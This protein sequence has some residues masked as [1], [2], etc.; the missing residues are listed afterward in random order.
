MRSG[1]PE[2][3][4]AQAAPRLWQS[5]L[6]GETFRRDSDA[7]DANALLNYGY[8][9]L[10]TSWPGMVAAGLLPAIGLF[11]SNRSNAF[12]LADDLMEPLRPL[13][14]RHVPRIMA[15]G[16]SRT[17]AGN[18]SRAAGSVGRSGSSGAAEGR[19]WLTCEPWWHRW[20]AATKERPIDW[21]FPRHVHQRVPVH[22]GRSH[23]RPSR[24]NQEGDAPMPISSSS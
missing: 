2:N 17:Q 7:P 16:A 14:D 22:V 15:A 12:C 3:T 4:K 23:V 6:P 1:D 13:V 11:H 9:V 18:E 21:R 10:R 19:S 8:A 20:S 5:W 24:E